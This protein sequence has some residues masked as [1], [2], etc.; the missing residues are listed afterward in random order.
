MN[1]ISFVDELVKVGGVR[2]L[3]KRAMDIDGGDIPAGMMDPAPSP[4]SMRVVP[5]EVATR[6]A[7]AGLASNVPEGM[8]GSSSGTKRPIDRER[9]NRPYVER[10]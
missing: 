2:C 3:A 9:F 7:N 1:L 5:D 4:P 6:V 10:R 8:L